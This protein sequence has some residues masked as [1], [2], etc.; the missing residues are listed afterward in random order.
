MSPLKVTLSRAQ[1]QQVIETSEYLVT[2]LTEASKAEPLS[3][4][5]KLGDIEEEEGGGD[6]SFT[7]NMT[8][9]SRP[10]ASAT[11]AAKTSSAA[12]NTSLSFGG[13]YL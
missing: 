4:T 11:G 8:A 5:S 2:S 12:E 3:S 1:Y 6:A 9:R 13:K 10:A 7:I